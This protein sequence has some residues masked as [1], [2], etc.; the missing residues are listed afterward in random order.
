[1]DFCAND[2]RRVIEKAL[3]GQIDNAIEYCLQQDSQNCSYEIFA[4]FIK[5]VTAIL[6]NKK[7]IRKV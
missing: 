5:G 7:V 2:T 4:G 6:G 3:T 1:M